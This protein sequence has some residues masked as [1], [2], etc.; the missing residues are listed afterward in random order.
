MICSAFW[1]SG[2]FTLIF[3][4]T[5][6]K[7]TKNVIVYLVYKILDCDWTK[8]S[9]LKFGYFVQTRGIFNPIIWLN[10]YRYGLPYKYAVMRHH[11]PSAYYFIA[12][13]LHSKDSHSQFITFVV[14]LLYSSPLKY[15][16]ALNSDSLLMND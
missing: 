2:L 1:R 11:Q 10:Y 13:R 6:P 8:P 7:P 9:H 5:D 3:F 4:V 12:K 14:K 15:N 16:T